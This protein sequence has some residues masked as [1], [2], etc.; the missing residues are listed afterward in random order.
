VLSLDRIQAALSDALR[1]HQA[2]QIDEAV[3]VYAAVLAAVPANADA[4]HLR[5]LAFHQRGEQ[6]RAATSIRRALAIDISQPAFHLNLGQAAAAQRRPGEAAAATRRAICI[7]P[8]NPQAYYNLGIALDAGGDMHGAARCLGRSARIFAASVPVLANLAA[9]LQNLGARDAAVANAR[10]AIAL[11]PNAS[12]PYNCLAVSLKDL[13]L[14]T[15]SVQAFRRALALESSSTVQRNLLLT[16]HYL[17]DLDRAEIMREHG[18]WAEG[19]KAERCRLADVDRSPD[20]R[21]SIGYLSGDLRMHVVGRNLIGLVENHDRRRVEVTMYSNVARPDSMTARFRAAADRWRDVHHLSDRDVADR[22]AGDRIDILVCCAGHVGENRLE[23]AA[24]KPAPILVSLL[25]VTSSGL[26]TVDYWLTDP[27]LHPPETAEPFTEAL[28]RLPCFYLHQPIAD[29]PDPGPLPESANGCITFGSCNN[30]AKLSP[31]TIAAWAAVLRAVPGSRLALWFFDAF[32]I[33]SLRQRLF[34]EFGRLGIDSARLLLEGSNLGRRGQ[35]LAFLQQID[36]GL[37]PLPFNGATTT[38]E[39]LWMGI[40]VVT[41]AGDRF[42]ARVGAST[43][44]AI[45][46]DHLIATDQDGMVRIAAALAA[47]R[48]Q[49]AALRAGLRSRVA[50]SILCDRAAYTRSVEDAYATMWKRTVAG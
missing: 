21:L 20:R 15:S 48:A 35:H 46:L 32:Q 49:R 4:H 27:R 39:Q 50:A 47:D 6:S 36:I 7:E 34:R 19:L 17:D 38:F 30:P 25:D 1:K 33:P 18:R 11:A 31:R 16:L 26:V 14:A 29:A 37:D 44:G 2:G 12:P 5:G 40:P 10:R 23:V 41:V 13:G 3:H 42:T 24:C 28:F 43:L 45:G 22:I 8:R 9:F